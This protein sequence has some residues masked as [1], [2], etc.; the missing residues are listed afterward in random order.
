MAVNVT[1]H[2][3]VLC[4]FLEYSEARVCCAT[5]FALFKVLAIGNLVGNTVGN[6]A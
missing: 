4:Y 5:S 2:I 1:L 3:I 6:T